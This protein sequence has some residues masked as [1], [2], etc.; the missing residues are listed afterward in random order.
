M[1]VQCMLYAG[2]THTHT[3]TVYVLCLLLSLTH[4]HGVYFM[5][6]S[7]THTLARTL[8]FP[9]GFVGFEW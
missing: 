5:P 3:C 9:I 8:S 6:A 1:Y 2:F 4:T 7:L